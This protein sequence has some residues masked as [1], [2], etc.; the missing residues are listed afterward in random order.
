MCAQVA[1]FWVAARCACSNPPAH[2]WGVAAPVVP[3]LQVNTPRPRD[4]KSLF[5]HLVVE[6]LAFAPTLS[7]SRE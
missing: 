1:I 2:Q 3:I 4:M 7:G 5:T 6:E